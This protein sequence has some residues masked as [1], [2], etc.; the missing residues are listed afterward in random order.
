MVD[1]FYSLF[2]F[3]GFFNVNEVV[4]FSFRVCYLFRFLFSF[5]IMYEII[6]F[7]LN[8]F[9]FKVSDWLCFGI[10]NII[11]GQYCKL[12][13]FLYQVCDKFICSSEF[14]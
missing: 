10:V 8:D 6:V 9:N 11:C 12:I 4:D 14:L 7:G 1:Y 2:F 13:L 5:D 3:Q